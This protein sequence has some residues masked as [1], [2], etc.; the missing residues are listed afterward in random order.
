MK[1]RRLERRFRNQPQRFSLLSMNGDT[2]SLI[3]VHAKENIERELQE[4]VND[5]TKSVKEDMLRI[6]REISDFVND[7][8]PWQ[9]SEDEFTD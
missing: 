5:P 7:D 8:D 3:L 4:R 6:I 1:I 9:R 2:L